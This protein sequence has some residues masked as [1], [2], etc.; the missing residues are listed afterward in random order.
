M[1]AGL[2]SDWYVIGIRLR[3]PVSLEKET[4]LLGRR[5]TINAH[6]S[7]EILVLLAELI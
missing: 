4:E 7:P 5:V 6:S 2:E 1:S 3:N